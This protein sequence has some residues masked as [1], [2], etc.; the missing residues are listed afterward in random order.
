[1]NRPSAQVNRQSA[2]LLVKFSRGHV[3]QWNQQFG[4]ILLYFH[5]V[6]QVSHGNRPEVSVLKFS[7]RLWRHPEVI[8]VLNWCLRL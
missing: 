2:H 6:E 4:L 1:M 8:V 3:S 5:R 7:Q